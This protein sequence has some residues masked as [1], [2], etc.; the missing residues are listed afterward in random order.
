MGKNL[1]FYYITDKKCF[2]SIKKVQYF[3][4]ER[5]EFMLGNDDKAKLKLYDLETKFTH[6]HLDSATYEM[7]LSGTKPKHLYACIKA[8]LPY[9]YRATLEGNLL[10]YK[11]QEN[12]ELSTMGTGV[13]AFTNSVKASPDLFK[14][15]I[16]QLNS[17]LTLSYK[18]GLEID[19]Y[20]A[21][22]YKQLTQDPERCLSTEPPILSWEESEYAFKKF[23]LTYLKPGSYPAWSS[24]VDRLDYPDIFCAWVWSLFQ[25][26]D[27]GRQALWIKGRGG[28]GKSTV[29]RAISAVFGH[30]YTCAI[31]HRS[32]TE[33]WFFGE[34]YSKRLAVYADCKNP[35]LISESRI[36]SLLGGDQVNIEYKG[37]K[38]FIG[39]V[40]SKLLIGSNLSPEI[41]TQKASERTRVL[42]LEVASLGNIK[43]DYQ[44]E[45]KLIAEAP[46]FLA[47]CKE[48]YERLCPT[49]LVIEEPDSMKQK[50]DNLCGSKES[51]AVDRFIDDELDFGAQYAVQLNDLLVYF[52]NFLAELHLAEK[53]NYAFGDLK[54]KLADRGVHLKRTEINGKHGRYMIGI[55]PKF[56]MDGTELKGRRK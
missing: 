32:Y 29:I 39:K 14:L 48:V 1:Q 22:I 46:Q 9:L 8:Q 38:S 24:F 3:T 55:R 7:N 10:L 19:D 47:H 28:D 42:Y 13:E 17:E 12:K 11:E 37:E 43:P 23:S 45:Q 40:Y 15:F 56:D 18:S 34:C 30:A 53:V 21:L 6:L 2:A 27:F 54:E 4:R 49:K 41:D 5:A 36:H 31:S 33:K 52:R 51:S 50:F 20:C 44:Y 25:P 16:D 26:D 35:R